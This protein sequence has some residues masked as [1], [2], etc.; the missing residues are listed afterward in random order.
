MSTKLWSSFLCWN[1]ISG[2]ACYQPPQIWI[3]DNARR[4][5]VQNL[6]LGVQNRAK[7]VQNYD[8]VF[9]VETT[10]GG[11]HVTSPLKFELPIAQ[12]GMVYKIWDSVCKIVQNKYKVV[13]YFSFSKSVLGGPVTCTYP[14]ATLYKTWKSQG[15][16][17]Y[18]EKWCN[19]DLDKEILWDFSLSGKHGKFGKF[20]WSGTRVGE[21][22]PDR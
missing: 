6:G 20:C 12:E 19:F 15:I 10:F 13:I 18:L 5:G 7:R 1:C 21:N 9:Y 16:L 11:L 14:L 22:F 3:A 4:N 8:P 2:A 17:V